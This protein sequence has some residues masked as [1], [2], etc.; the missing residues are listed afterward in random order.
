VES[1]RKVIERFDGIPAEHVHALLENYF[2]F[3]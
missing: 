3:L 1:G 2:N